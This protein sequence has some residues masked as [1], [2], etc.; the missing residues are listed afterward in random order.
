MKGVL[1]KIYRGLEVR[2]RTLY[3]QIPG[4]STASTQGGLLVS[5][6]LGSSDPSHRVFL[7]K[8]LTIMKNM[9]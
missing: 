8:N 4:V 7:Q 3:G 2:Q 1:V 9:S 6:K 5:H